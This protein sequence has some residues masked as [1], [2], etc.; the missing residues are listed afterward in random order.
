MEKEK[1]AVGA[2]CGANEGVRGGGGGGGGGSCK[3]RASPRTEANRGASGGEQRQT[4]A[5]TTAS[6]VASWCANAVVSGGKVV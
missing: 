2:G 4:E 5:R 1:E 3:C 6:G